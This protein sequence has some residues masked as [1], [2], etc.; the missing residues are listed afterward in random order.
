MTK[1]VLSLEVSCESVDLPLDIVVHMFYAGSRTNLLSG[2]SCS[3]LHGRPG[4]LCTYRQIRLRRPC[5]EA[6]GSHPDKLN[7]HASTSK[8]KEKRLLLNSPWVLQ[9]CE[10]IVRRRVNAIVTALECYRIPALEK[11]EIENKRL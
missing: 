1:I 8:V 10:G 2:R 6:S 9:S 4:A 5:I 3:L 7:A 11:P